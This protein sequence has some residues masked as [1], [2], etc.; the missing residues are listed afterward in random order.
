[1]APLAWHIPFARPQ[2][3]VCHSARLVK[4]CP[5]PNLA[6]Q[7][8]RRAA[9]QTRCLFLLECAVVNKPLVDAGNLA[10]VALEDANAVSG[11]IV[12]GVALNGHESAVFHLHDQA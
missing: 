4:S 7:G 5:V 10:R 1:M 6:P 12:V 2:A 8:L 11:T 9:L 3:E